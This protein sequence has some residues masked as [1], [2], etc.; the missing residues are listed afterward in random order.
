MIWLY[1]LV[2]FISIAALLIGLVLF[3]GLHIKLWGEE[4][5]FNP[6]RVTVAALLVALGLAGLSVVKIW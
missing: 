1:A 2:R 4:K 6:L 5:T 3:E